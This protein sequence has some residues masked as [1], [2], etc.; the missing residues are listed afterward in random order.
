MFSLIFWVCPLG[1][2][3]IRGCPTA[4]RQQYLHSQKPR[5]ESELTT[6]PTSKNL[7]VAIVIEKSLFEFRTFS[8]R[9][10]TFS[11]EIYTPLILQLGVVLRTAVSGLLRSE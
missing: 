9:V 2:F 7:H 8:L 5:I 10:H 6:P 4:R 1:F 11:F 3:S